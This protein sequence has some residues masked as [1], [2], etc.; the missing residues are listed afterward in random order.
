ML[1]NCGNISLPTYNVLF[2]ILIEQMS[3]EI[4]FDSQRYSIYDGSSTNELRFENPAMLKVIAQLLTQS[5]K[6][7]EVLKVKKIFL[8]D[9]LYLCKN[10]KENRRF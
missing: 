9:L 8:E 4:H 10:L 2:E 7:E 3:P 5:S 1:I 6:C